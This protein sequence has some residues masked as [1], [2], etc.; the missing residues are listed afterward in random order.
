MVNVLPGMQAA[1]VDIGLDKNAFLYV[2]DINVENS[3]FDF[4]GLNNE[5]QTRIK[6]LSIKDII[7]E[8]QAVTVQILKEPMGT[9]V[10]R[11]TTNITLPGRY[12]VLMPTLII[13]GSPENRQRGRTQP[14]Q[15]N[16]RIR[17]T[18]GNRTDSKDGRQR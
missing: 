3:V 13:S 17:K 8:G 1:F 12:V 7:K 10:H 4:N 14:P 11:L 9:K 2:G 16:S 6:S 15:A 18:Q 5:G